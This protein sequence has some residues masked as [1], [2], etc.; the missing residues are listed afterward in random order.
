LPGLQTFIGIPTQEAAFGRGP[1]LETRQLLG[2][3]MRT[4][5]LLVE[6]TPGLQRLIARLL[7][8]RGF[9]VCL[10]ADGQEALDRLAFFEPDVVLTDL[11]MPV[12]DGFELIRRI[13]AMTALDGVPVLAMTATASPQAE[14]EARAAGAVDVLIKPL[15]GRT[16]ADRIGGARQPDGVHPGPDPAAHAPDL[17]A[18][19]GAQA[20]LKPPTG[21]GMTPETAEL[22]RKVETVLAEARQLH[23][24]SAGARHRT[25]ELLDRLVHTRGELRQDRRRLADTVRQTLETL[26]RS[27]PYSAPAEEP[28]VS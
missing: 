8:Q 1:Q 15:D 19:C 10:A 28:T 11:M 20:G 5:I 14:R 24:A 18:R 2:A 9:E 26:N 25:R 7:T 22:I 21:A 3:A 12:L 27:R 13:R 17:G 6:D 4:R 23:A 16:L